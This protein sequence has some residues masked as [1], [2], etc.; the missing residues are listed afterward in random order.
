MGPSLGHANTPIEQV[1]AFYEY[2]T[3][4]QSWRDF[5]LVAS[6]STEH[7]VDAA[8]C[9]EE[10]RWMAKEIERKAKNLKKQEMLRIQTLVSRA[11]AADP[12]L[13]MEK[14]RL[15]KEKQEREEARKR[16]EEEQRLKKEADEAMQ[17]IEKEKKEQQEK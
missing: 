14:E 7:D 2:W 15:A 3:H 12:R 16:K 13:K 5:T 4:F 17:R 1:H 6:K 9:R 8:E 11:M 10:K